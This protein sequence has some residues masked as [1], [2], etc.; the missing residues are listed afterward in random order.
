MTKCCQMGERCCDYCCG[1]CRMC[2]CA[3]SGAGRLLRRANGGECV[4][5][6]R[7]QLGDVA[8]CTGHIGKDTN[9]RPKISS[10]SRTRYQGVEPGNNLLGALAEDDVFA[11]RTRL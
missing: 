10:L 9:P 5:P 4:P 7:I 2:T 3:S 1:C 6:A 8:G 11:G